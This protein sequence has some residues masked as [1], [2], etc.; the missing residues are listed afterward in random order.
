MSWVIVV[1]V[2]FWGMTILL[3]K[4]LIRGSL[5]VDIITYIPNNTWSVSA[6]GSARCG[7]GYVGRV[8]IAQTIIKVYIETEIYE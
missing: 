4:D 6:I 1:V 8:N 2:A 7:A 5:L 3:R